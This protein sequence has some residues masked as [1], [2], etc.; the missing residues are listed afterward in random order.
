MVWPSFLT[1]LPTWA[2]HTTWSSRK[3]GKWSLGKDCSPVCRGIQYHGQHRRKR[4]SD[5]CEMVRLYSGLLHYGSDQLH[6]ECS[7]DS[8]APTADE[9]S[10]WPVGRRLRV[11]T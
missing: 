3:G 7:Q 5:A 8:R 9:Q 2:S 10:E 6:S 11:G 4:S 1:V